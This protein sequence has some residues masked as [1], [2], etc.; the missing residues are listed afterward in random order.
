MNEDIEN[1]KE[2]TELKQRVIRFTNFL[3]EELKEY[4]VKMWDSGEGY[5]ILVDKVEVL[6]YLSGMVE[7]DIR[8]EKLNS[9][10]KNDK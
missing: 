8:E 7:F 5:S 6:F 10:Q 4:S 2:W 1:E 3:N 9:E